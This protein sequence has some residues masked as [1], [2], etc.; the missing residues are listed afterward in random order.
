MDHVQS[1][2]WQCQKTPVAT[3]KS[4][5]TN[6]RKERRLRVVLTGDGPARGGGFSPVERTEKSAG[7]RSW[8]WNG[9]RSSTG[10]RWEVIVGDRASGK[11]GQVESLSRDLCSRDVS[12]SVSSRRPAAAAVAV[13]CG[14]R[15]SP[16]QPDWRAVATRPTQAPRTAV[17]PS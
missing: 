2:N 8:P 7:D 3:T 9:S 6:G 15:L 4:W 1:P 17:D 11:R 12:L 16:D 10:P 13:D 14:V 5:G